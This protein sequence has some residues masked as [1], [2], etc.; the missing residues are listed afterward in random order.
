MR[1]DLADSII[2]S[3]MKEDD[4]RARKKTIKCDRLFLV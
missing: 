3:T 4:Y 2:D 1:E